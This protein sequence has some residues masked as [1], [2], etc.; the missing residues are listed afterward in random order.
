MS[1]G[2]NVGSG[3]NIVILCSVYFVDADRT[4]H[5][6]GTVAVVPDDD[7]LQKRL[8]A[9]TALVMSILIPLHVGAI[10]TLVSQV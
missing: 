3:S 1:S 6:D 9:T 10:A 5:R 7:Q 2:D 8:R 4:K